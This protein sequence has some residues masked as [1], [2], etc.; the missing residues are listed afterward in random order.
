MKRRTM[1]LYL[2]V[3]EF[4]PG[5]YGVAAASEYYFAKP[6]GQLTPAEAALLATALPNPAI[7]QVAAPS[8]YMRERQRW[9]LVQMQRLKREGVRPLNFK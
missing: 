7:Y 3:V 6:A 4:G 1:E 2:N 8:E 9:V 5:I